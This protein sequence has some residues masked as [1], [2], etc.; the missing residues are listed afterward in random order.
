MPA[1]RPAW[2]GLEARPPWADAVRTIVHMQGSRVRRAGDGP[3]PAPG[4]ACA[5]LCSTALTGCQATEATAWAGALAALAGTA[6][7][8]FGLGWVLANW[9]GRQRWQ[10]QQRQSAQEQRAQTELLDGWTLWTDPQHRLQRVHPPVGA[11][12]PDWQRGPRPGA[13]LWEH[14]ESSVPGDVAG[15]RA[16]LESQVPFQDLRVRLLADGSGWWLRAVPRHDDEGRFAGFSACARPTATLDGLAADQAGLLALMASLDGPALLA[17]PVTAPAQGW[18]V[19]HLNPAAQAWLQ[20]EAG[21]GPR[22]PAWE[23]VL[24]R[25]PATLAPALVPGEHAALPSGCNKA[26]CCAGSTPT[27]ARACC[28]CARPARPNKPTRTPRPRAPRSASRCR[29]TCVRPSAWWKASRAS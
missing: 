5:L 27:P 1:F 29:T 11:P 16:R 15:L 17:G 18:Q 9:R 21:A 3:R 19:L 23:E 2:A 10:S 24:A 8:A 20:A 12:A 28:C 26:G 6:A 4:A 22:L 13:L 14:F 25:L 7:L